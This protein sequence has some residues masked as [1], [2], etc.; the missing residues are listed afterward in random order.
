MFKQKKVFICFS[1]LAVVC[2][3]G[4]AFL[5]QQTYAKYVLTKKSDGIVVASEFYFESDLLYDEADGY[6]PDYTINSGSTFAFTLKNYPDDLRYN[7]DEINFT[8]AV[9]PEV[10]TDNSKIEIKI[11]DKVSDTGSI[12]GGGKNDVTVT[13]S[14][15]E[16]NITYTIEV[17]GKT[18][19]TKTLCANVTPY[20]GGAKVY[21]N[22]DLT[23]TQ[24]ILLTVWT[25][26]YEGNIVVTYPAG[27]IPDNTYATMSNWTTA[28]LS[29]TV[30]VEKYSSYTF[31]FFKSDNFSSSDITSAISVKYN[32][33]EAPLSQSF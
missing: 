22:I 6:T 9:T 31:R 27:L 21:K 15:L 18:A 29:Y 24:Y 19:Y 25:K 16:D 26:E 4:L 10:T 13:V 32:D 17:V 14:G 1:V 23:N 12:T 2:L 20:S 28:T 8:V 11:G 30:E 3:L 33:T 5:I 7:E